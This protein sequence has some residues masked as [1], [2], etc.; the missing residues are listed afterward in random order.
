VR[1]MGQSAWLSTSS[2][3]LQGSEARVNAMETGIGCND[4]ISWSN[5]YSIWPASDGGLEKLQGGQ[6][7]DKHIPLPTQCLTQTS[8]ICQSIGAIPA[9]ARSRLMIEKHRHP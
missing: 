9:S 1:E 4:G 2:L 7:R 5:N 8:G 6:R 3:T